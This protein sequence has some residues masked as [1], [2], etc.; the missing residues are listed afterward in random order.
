MQFENPGFSGGKRLWD[1]QRRPGNPPPSVAPAV[2]PASPSITEVII[3]EE[4]TIPSFTFVKPTTENVM[5]V[6][7]MEPA[8]KLQTFVLVGGVLA[9][10][11]FLQK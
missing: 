11:Y 2:T 9:A 4:T 8:S 3:P 5:V 10:A 6:D 7:S 1:R